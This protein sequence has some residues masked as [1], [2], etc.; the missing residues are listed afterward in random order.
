[1]F[2]GCTT[3][4]VA[5]GE[6]WVVAAGG[7]SRRFNAVFVLWLLIG[8]I[9][10]LVFGV[11]VRDDDRVVLVGILLLGVTAGSWGVAAVSRN[12]LAL[13]LP[14][15]GFFATLAISMIGASGGRSQSRPPY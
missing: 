15:A 2:A 13:L 6:A 8:A 1:M 12:D 10:A 11:G 7:P 3:A 4:V 9:P 14:I 5:A